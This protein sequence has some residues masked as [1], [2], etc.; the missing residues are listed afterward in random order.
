MLHSRVASA[1]HISNDGPSTAVSMCD[2]NLCTLKL[3]MIHST[4]PFSS[5][6]TATPQAQL[7]LFPVQAP[8]ATAS[9]NVSTFSDNMALPVHRW[10]RFSAGYSAEWASIVVHER[11]TN[12]SS[13]RA[14]VLD[15]FVGSGTT[16]LAAASSGCNSFGW[17]AQTLI[18]R[19]AD[20]K[21]QCVSVNPTELRT[22]AREVLVAAESQRLGLAFQDE[23]SLLQKCYTED[24]LADL[25][26]LQAALDATKPSISPSV[27]K[28]L[29][30][31]LLSILRP[32][33]HAATAQWQ[34]VQPRKSKA[35]PADARRAFELKADQ[36]AY[37]I[38]AFAP[39][40]N[41]EMHIACHDSRLA[42]QIPN[43]TVDLVVTSP[44]YLN[45][46]D[47]ADA[48]R[49]E[50]TFFGE[51]R[52]WSDLKGVRES[53]VHAC[54]Q[55]MTGYDTPNA[56]EDPILSPIVDR[57]RPIYDDLAELRLH[58]AGRKAYHSMV[59]AYF[60]DMAAIWHNLRT[61]LRPGGQ[62]IFV[63]GDSAPYGVYT[64]VEEFHGELAV[65]AGFERFAFTKTRDRNIKWKNR[66]H[67]VPLKEGIL[68]VIG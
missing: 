45:N 15:P 27:W 66:K 11:T 13:G 5:A 48:T 51:V 30:L 12:P 62:A 47:Y 57:L 61:V 49:L 31:N 37:D 55:H 33:S 21:L 68:E 39:C 26:R 22:T 14:T 16:L 54:S 56:L 32:V 25:R 20:A 8:S 3:H 10:F 23:P 19:I 17:E 42:P 58:R 35:R 29:W 18:Y 44:P 43:G 63:I 2:N 4:S 64:P 7:S 67:R 41:G 1:D 60:R 9:R 53:L 40:L 52:S 36:M 28:L 50:M 46:Y 65:A 34:Y 24:A 6:S 38:E 59:V